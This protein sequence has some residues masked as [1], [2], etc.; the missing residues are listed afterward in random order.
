LP[1]ERSVSAAFD[2]CVSLVRPS[3]HGTPRPA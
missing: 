1:E 3:N 2:E